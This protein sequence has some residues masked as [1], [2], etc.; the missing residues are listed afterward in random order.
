MTELEASPTGRRLFALIR[1]EATA[2]DRCSSGNRPERS[3]A[4]VTPPQ[5][6]WAEALAI[7]RMHRE[8]VNLH[9]GQRIGEL[10]IKGDVQGIA[11]RTEIARLL[12]GLR[13]ARSIS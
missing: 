11:S 9:V 12:D 3:S 6:R 1:C 2:S 8:D 10:A 4:V 5:E 7:L 13:C